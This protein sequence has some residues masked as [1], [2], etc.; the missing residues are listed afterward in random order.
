MLRRRAVLI[1]VVVLAA[2]FVAGCRDR[3]FGGP[4][5]PAEDCW[6]CL[7]FGSKCSASVIDYDL[8]FDR[9]CPGMQCTVAHHTCALG[10]REEGAYWGAGEENVFAHCEDTSIR[11]PGFPCRADIDCV[12]PV[13]AMLASNLTNAVTGLGGATSGSG[14]LH[15]SE[16]GTCAFDLPGAGTEDFGESCS[17]ETSS[18]HAGPVVGFADTCSGGAC[19]VLEGGQAAGACTLSCETS[20]C[21]HGY[22]CVDVLDN[23]YTTWSTL[24]EPISPPRILACVPG[25]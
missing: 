8:T 7:P 13:G 16:E 12:T 14:E 3:A 10:C 1:A 5:G 23:R 24:Y 22:R 21:P 18:V 6:E 11:A 2:G 4:A 19:L 20:V 15:C 9:A 25:R 17:I